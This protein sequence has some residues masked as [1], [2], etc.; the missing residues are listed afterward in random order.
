MPSQTIIKRGNDAQY[1]SICDEVSN[2][3]NKEGKYVKTSCSLFVVS[4]V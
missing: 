1:F 3:S 4:L 2:T